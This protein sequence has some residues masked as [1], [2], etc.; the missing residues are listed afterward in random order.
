MNREAP[1]ALRA[2]DEG[3]LRHALDVHWDIK[4]H[5]GRISPNNTT[6]PAEPREKAVAAYL[7][8]VVQREN[9]GGITKNCISTFVIDEFG[10]VSATGHTP[11]TCVRV[12]G[13]LPLDPA[14]IK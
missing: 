4:E 12:K 7:K 3:C 10:S 2:R 6:Q 11:V 5:P 9:P 13:E 1:S 14:S 8:E